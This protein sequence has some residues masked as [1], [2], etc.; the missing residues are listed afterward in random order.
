[1]KNW[2]KV[3]LIFAVL[4]ITDFVFGQGCSQ[5]KLLAE[6]GSELD[7]ASFGTNINYG[8]LYLMA[9]PYIII[10]FIFRKKII[11]FIKRKFDRPV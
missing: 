2:N 5:C 10:F 11:Q 8:I 7:E 6:Q 1:M 9:M 4:M 3:T